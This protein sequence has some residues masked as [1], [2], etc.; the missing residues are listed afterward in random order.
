MTNTKNPDADPEVR[1][2]AVGQYRF[3]E[4][5]CRRHLTSKLSK[6]KAACAGRPPRAA[7]ALTVLDLP[8]SIGILGFSAA[9]ATDIFMI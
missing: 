6:N 5:S 8:G 4:R 7:Q 3:A 9:P 2:G 1:A